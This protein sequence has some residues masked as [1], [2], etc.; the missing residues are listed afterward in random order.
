MKG[1]KGKKQC[2]K[3]CGA[4]VFLAIVLL[5]V[6]QL[7]GEEKYDESGKGRPGP[8]QTSVWCDVDQGRGADCGAYPSPGGSAA[9]IKRCQ[10]FPRVNINHVKT[11]VTV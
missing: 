2:D 5:A 4:F 3:A 10:Q 9:N 6:S 8:T 1:D 7:L 11:V